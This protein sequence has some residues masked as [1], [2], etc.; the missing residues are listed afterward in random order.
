MNIGELKQSI[1]FKVDDLKSTRFSDEHLKNAINESYKHVY[2]ELIRENIYTDLLSDDVTFTSGNQEV[3]FSAIA[4]KEI[5]K[6]IHIQDVNENP[7]PVYSEAFSKRSNTRSVYLKRILRITLLV[8]RVSEIFLGWHVCPSSTF[9]L[10]VIYLPRLLDLSPGLSDDAVIDN[11]PSEHHDVVVLR[12]V[13]L[14]LG[15]DEDNARFWVQLYREALISMKESIQFANEETDV[16]V[17][18]Q[19]EDY[20]ASNRG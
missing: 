14:L 17:D 3:K 11:V 4:T 19:T 20:Y 9:T 6:I 7:I 18:L 2:R 12:A 10:T 1:R 13:I 8:G 15:T 5:Q 16:V